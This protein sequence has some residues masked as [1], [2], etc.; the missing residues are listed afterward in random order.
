MNRAGVNLLPTNTLAYLLEK[1][2]MKNFF[3]ST[4]WL[5]ASLTIESWANVIKLFYSVNFILGESVRVL[6]P[7][8]PFQP[9]LMFESKAAAYPEVLQRG[10]LWPFSTTLDESNRPV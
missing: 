10:K 8:K 1:S 3:D 5:R 9:S 2:V 7:G 4:C 6:D